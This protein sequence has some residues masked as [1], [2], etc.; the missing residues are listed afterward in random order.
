MMA[1]I[2]LRR[3][4]YHTSDGKIWT[5]SLVFCVVFNF[6]ERPDALGDQV[7]GLHFA[8]F[9]RKKRCAREWHE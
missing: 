9:L 1:R 6:L 7:A 8:Q 3:D 2:I 5:D 4:T